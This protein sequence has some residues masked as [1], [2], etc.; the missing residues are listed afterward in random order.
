MPKQFFIIS[1]SFQEN[2]GSFSGFIEQ[3]ARYAHKKQ[4]KTIIICGK[5]E[6]SEPDFQKLGYAEVFR[7]PRSNFPFFNSVVNAV[8]LSKYVKR[9]FEK[10]KL[11]PSD[12][13]IANGESALGLK[14]LKFILR[15]G[16][17]PVLAYLKNMEI[18]KNDVSIITRIARFAHCSFLYLI[19]KTYFKWPIATIYS[20]EETRRLF[21]KDYK[22]KDRPYFIPHSGVRYNELQQTK[23]IKINGRAILFVSAGTEKI[24]KGIIYLERAIP[25]IFTK[26]KD[27][28]ILHVGDKFEWNIPEEYKSRIISIGKVKWE[29]MKVYYASADFIVSCSLHEMFPNA[30][31]EAM[32]SGLPVVTSDINGASEYIKHL[33]DGYIYRRGDIEGLK[34]GIIYL[35]DNK[36]VIKEMS[37]KISLKAKRLDYKIYSKKFLVFAEGITFNEKK[38]SYDLLN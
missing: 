27:V 17:Q 12:I 37:K 1:Q 16:D 9:Y 20:S 7:F 35:L 5:R 3:T 26:Y 24:R 10:N 22:I 28:K 31:M 36:S 8:K 11:D 33:E 25:E 18:A 2:K 21:E 38:D 19:E 15:S 30:I 13:I 34:K 4:Y 14:N 29:K 23:K 32:A 6:E